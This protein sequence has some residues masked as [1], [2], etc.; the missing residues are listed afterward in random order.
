MTVDVSFIP[1]N[2]LPQELK[3]AAERKIEYPYSDVSVD[4]LVEQN[5][6]KSDRTALFVN[7]RKRFREN[8]R[9]FEENLFIFARDMFRQRKFDIAEKSFRYLV[10]LGSLKAASKEY[11][12]KIYIKQKNT[13]GI[14][15][16]KKRIQIQLSQPY[17]LAAERRKLKR[18][19][20]KYFAIN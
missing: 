12:L 4:E 20:G 3:E 11:L 2:L 8:Y 5:V 1:G 13:V 9:V 7:N 6:H 18:I 14:K 10:E 16:I 17:S 19:L 15:W